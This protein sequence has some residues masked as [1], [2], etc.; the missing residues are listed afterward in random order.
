MFSACRSGLYQYYARHYR[1]SSPM[2]QIRFDD[3]EP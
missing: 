1:P 2:E 3:N